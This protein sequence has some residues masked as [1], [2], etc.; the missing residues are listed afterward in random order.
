MVAK[1]AA[2]SFFIIA[3]LLFGSTATFPSAQ[4]VSEG[5]EQNFSAFACQFTANF[6]ID[7]GIDEVK[8]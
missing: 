7:K 3:A 5:Y 1:R 6:V 4:A 2:L 8:K